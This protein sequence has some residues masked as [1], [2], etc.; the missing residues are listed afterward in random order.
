MISYVSTRGQAPELGFADAMLAGLASDG[1]L[2]CPATLP[3][4]G[5][6]APGADYI[7]TASAIM[8]PFV[9]GSF[10]QSEFKRLVREAYSSF[11]H[12][13]VV[14]VRPLGE[15][16]WVA[17]LFWGPT[18]AFKDV[19]LQLLGRL[20]DAEL[21]RRDQHV[22]VL[23][24][25]SGDTG[26]AAIEALRGSSRA[27]VVILHPEGRVS[28]IQ[29][30][31][32]TTVDVPN[33]ANVAVEGTFD[34]CQDL[35]KAAFGSPELRA[36]LNL[37]A[38]NSI[39]WARVMAQIV[40]YATS[41]RA[42]APDGSPV[43]FCVPTGNFG[44]VLAGW[45]ARR[46]GVPIHQ[47]VIASN[48]NDILTRF[49][50]TG[51]LTAHAVQPSLSPSM[52]IQVSSNFE[53]ALWEASGRDG[54][55]VAALLDQF[56]ADGDVDVPDEWVSQLRSQFVAGSVDDDATLATIADLHSSSGAVFDPHSAVGLAVA[57][58]YAEVGVP[59]ITL[60]TAHPAKFPDAVERAIGRRPDLPAFLSEL[61]SRRE[62]CQHAPAELGA[63]VEIART[64]RAI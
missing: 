61:L 47:L 49:F 21:T 55:A 17:E 56:R 60:A 11:R 31:Q 15:N 35:V 27:D 40:Y 57:A 10:D 33:V 13:E 43:S 50:Q 1:G 34:D 41:A 8:W 9:E 39:N 29:R 26:S 18:L 7:D 32:M 64:L 58:N 16:Q 63:I 42:V 12:P 45:Y 36:Q 28:D 2:Y 37:A 48:R 24:A 22:T 46:L 3:E 62:Y 30:R 51:R 54:E 14:P 52:D 44:N 5:S 25:T 59:M 20:L 38:V 53:R 4:L 23:G 19:A 6:L